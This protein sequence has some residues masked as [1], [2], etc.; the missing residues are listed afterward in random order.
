MTSFASAFNR[1]L[2]ENGLPALGTVEA[3]DKIHRF[4]APPDKEENSWYVLHQRGDIVMGAFGC[5]KRDFWKPFCSK[6][7][8][9]MTGDE[10][11]LSDQTVRDIR[12]QLAAEEKAGH[13]AARA[14]CNRWFSAFPKA[15]PDQPYLKSK[16]VPV[17]GDLRLFTED[18]YQGWLALP[19]R[20]NA[21]TIHS[22]QFISPDGDKLYCY[23]GRKRG[24]YFPVAQVPGGPI[25]ICEGYATAASLHLATGWTVIAAMDCGNLLPVATEIRKLHPNRT[26]ILCAD[27]DQ[28]TEDNPGL[29]KSKAAAKAIKAVVAFP[30]FGDETLAA[31]PTDFNDLHRI[32]GLAE[33]RTQVFEALPVVA[34][35][36]GDFK[37]PEKDDPTELLKH[38]YLC[39]R[40]SLLLNGPAGMGKSSFLVQAAALWANCLDL[41]DI[42]PRKP[43]KT[44]IIQAEN[45]D[46][47]IAQMRDGICTGLHFTES[48]R[49]V[50][51]ENVLIYS[52]WGFTGRAFCL[53]IVRP[54]LD[55]HDPNLFAIDPALSFI[56]GD[57]KEQ[58]VVGQ[59]LREYLNPIIFEHTCACLMMHH[60]NKPLTGKEKGSW[61]N[62]EMAYTGSGSAEWA[63]W[64]RA[65]LSLQST[66]TPGYYNLHASKRGSRLGWTNEN[67]DLSYQKLVAWSRD[68]NTIYWR[69]PDPDEL[70]EDINNPSNAGRTS[71]VAKIASMNTYD[72]LAQCP[73]EGESQ[74]AIARRLESWLAKKH[75][76]ASTNTCRRALQSLVSSQKLTKSPDS[77]LY[78]KGPNA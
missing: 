32:E 50:F 28:F 57:V 60:T 30:E 11:R 52:S 71:I 54:I 69:T 7:R 9:A 43:L 26:I 13:D 18:L 49:R 19:L 2:N 1:A 12:T 56:G 6:D 10:R 55:L 40:G 65:V 27:N 24:S 70:P 48:Q 45:D 51:F 46:G 34:R 47:D 58:K 5:W 63:N 21:G 44:V 15:P 77:G 64:P 25:L 16:G 73:Q 53:E 29:V 8:T 66:G 39:E 4:K 37:V 3:D 61:R 41:F 38:R 62:G 74:R 76:D 59:F 14:K 17:L 72:L 75:V 36:I 42:C 20:D 22:A 67:D 23:Q 33:V 68:K 78:F 31:K 35:P